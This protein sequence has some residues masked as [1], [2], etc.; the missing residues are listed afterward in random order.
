MV[1]T[2]LY[3][4]IEQLNSEYYKYVRASIF[5]FMDKEAKEY[6]TNLIDAEET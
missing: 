4:T 2:P 3:N 6:L 1:K 5:N